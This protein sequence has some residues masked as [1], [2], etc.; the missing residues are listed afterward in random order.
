[1][2][3]AP[4]AHQRTDLQYHDIDKENQHDIFQSPEYAQ[5]L[6]NYYK[7]KEVSRSS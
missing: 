5:D 4:P 7:I 2:S 6:F 3:T 1:M